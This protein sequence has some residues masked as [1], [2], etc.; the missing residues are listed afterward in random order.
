[1]NFPFF[2]PFQIEFQERNS[3]LKCCHN[4][5]DTLVSVWQLPHANFANRGSHR[6][7]FTRWVSQLG[8]SR[9]FQCFR[10]TDGLIKPAVPSGHKLSSLLHYAKRNCSTNVACRWTVGQ[11][12]G[13]PSMYIYSGK[14]WVNIFISFGKFYIYYLKCKIQAMLEEIF[15]RFSSSVIPHSLVPTILVCR[16]IMQIYALLN[17][18]NSISALVAGIINKQWTQVG[19][20]FR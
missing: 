8:W 7:T 14:I 10:L 9:V 4:E 13:P 6:R 16:S 18:G 5:R 15:L 1:M 2:L 12:N 3:K 20:P 17:L 11:N 19:Q